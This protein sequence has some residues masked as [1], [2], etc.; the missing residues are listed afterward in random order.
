MPDKTVLIVDD[1]PKMQRVLEIMLKQMGHRPLLAGN[2]LEALEQIEAHAVD[3][4]VSDLQMPQMNGLQ[5]LEALRGQDS[6]LPFIMITAY[7][8]VESAVEAMKHGA[9]DYI[10]RPFDV[11]QVELSITRALELGRV[12]RENRFLKSEVSKGWGE[13]VGQSAAMRQ[14]YE[15][16]GQVARGKTNVLLVGETGTGKE[17][18][19]RAIHQASPR[20]DALFVPIN[21]AAI[22]ADIL[23][24]E[25]FGHTKGAFTGAVKDRMGKFELAGGGTIFLDEITEMPMPLQAK[26]LRVLQEGVVER[27]GSNRPMEVDV[28]VIA[29]TN[30]NPR[31][32]I[33]DGKLRED[34]YYRIQVFTVELPPLRQ[35]LEDIPSLAGHFLD[36][37]SAKLG[38]PVPDIAPAA[39]ACLQRYPWP[40]NVR[41]LENVMERAV[42]LSGGE[43]VDVRH[44]PLEI[45]EHAP[46]A[47]GGNAAPA[48]ADPAGLAL[49]PAVEAL[50]R[51][52]IGRALEQTGGNKTRA[53]RLLEISERTLWYKLKKYGLS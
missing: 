46:Y 17:L 51:E 32:A 2:G 25:L 26:L 45:A 52:F 10:I 42:V 43:H 30:R 1:E 3:L 53:A 39:L 15:H 44:L 21:C 40:G 22:P 23:E 47:A 33:A 27:L 13:F 4:V 12:Q 18:A 41:E 16:I 36:K 5:L 37:H 9:C 19:A 38:Y 28:R 48:P 29:A 24:S 14:V 50:E 34:L 11:E 8:T 49:D 6:D 7:G 35:R 20:K 31:E